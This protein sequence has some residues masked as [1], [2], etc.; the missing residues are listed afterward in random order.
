MQKLRQPLKRIDLL[1]DTNFSAYC[2]D[3]KSVRIA[4]GLFPKGCVRLVKSTEF[5]STNTFLKRDDTIPA[6]SA[7]RRSGIIYNYGLFLHRP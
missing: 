3:K 1:Y 7:E 6:L 4:F 2:K 5:I